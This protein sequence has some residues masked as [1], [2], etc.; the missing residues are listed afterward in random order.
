MELK[1]RELAI[2]WWNRK[3]TQE[4]TEL[5]KKAKFPKRDFSALTGLE[6]EWIWKNQPHNCE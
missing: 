6:I 5:A 4:K 3:S 1:Y 2:R